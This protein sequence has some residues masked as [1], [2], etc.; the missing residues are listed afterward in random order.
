MNTQLPYHRYHLALLN[1]LFDTLRAQSVLMAQVPEESNLL[2]LERFEELIAQL[3]AGEHDALYS[4]QEV[5]C[6][7]ITR[8]PQ[9]AHMIPRDLLWYF[10]GD[11]LHYMPDEEIAQYQL[12]DEHQAEAAARG[13]EFNW[14]Q[15]RQLLMSKA[16][17]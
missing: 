13:E 10:G 12:L 11:C 4:G 9:V 16:Q 1:S 15:A 2:F 14:E 8:Y 5:I 7:V 3:E 17:G 6:Q